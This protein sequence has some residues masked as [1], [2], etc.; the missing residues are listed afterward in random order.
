MIIEICNKRIDSNEAADFILDSTLDS[1]VKE[2]K[3]RFISGD[4][5]FLFRGTE[6]ECRSVTQRP[7]CQKLLSLIEKRKIGKIRTHSG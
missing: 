3:L 1:D 7:E 2:L 4:E 5:I 6:E